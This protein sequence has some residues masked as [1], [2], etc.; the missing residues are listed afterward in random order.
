MTS[1]LAFGSLARFKS[2]TDNADATDLFF[3]GFLLCCWISLRLSGAGILTLAGGILRRT[4]ANTIR[5]KS[6]IKWQRKIKLN[7]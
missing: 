2:I 5:K 3:H 4:G 7:P 6:N 1:S